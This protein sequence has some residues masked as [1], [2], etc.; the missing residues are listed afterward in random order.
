MLRII[1]PVLAGLFL[2]VLWF[3]GRLAARSFAFSRSKT[4]EEALELCTVEYE[5]FK[6]EWFDSLAFESFSVSSPRGYDLKGVFLT[7]SSDKTIIMCH[8]HTFTWQGQVKY[9]PFFIDQGWNIVAYNHR[10][11]GTSGGDYCTAG[12]FEKMDLGLVADWAW[13]QFPH[14]KTFGVQ[15]ESM[16][17][18]TVLQYLPMDSRLDFV[19]AD[20]PYS[21][22]RALYHHQLGNKY[23]IP[24]FLQKP[25]IAFSRDYLKRRCN[26]DMHQVSPRESI[27]KARVPLL[28]FH[29]TDD[30]YVP[31][32]M[33]Q[34][35]YEARKDYAPTE[36]LL[37]EG[38]K[39]AE[40]IK[41]DREK[42]ES[43]LKIFLEKYCAPEK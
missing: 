22:M 24:A 13:E 38:A 21:D 29:G 9:M 6:K 14:T 28:L 41:V 5:D 39:H 3:L 20:C 36:L 1:L 37:I 43:V 18:A 27:M 16:G 8:G 33:S 25:V 34:E 26:F 23:R 40:D 35:M 30:T 15:G 7:G 17:A 42:Y 10:Y 11:H 32:R 31:T 19:L 2:F 4:E 12:F